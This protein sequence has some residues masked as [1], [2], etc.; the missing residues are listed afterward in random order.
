MCPL[1]GVWSGFEQP[2][3]GLCLCVS[4]RDVAILSSDAPTWHLLN[5]IENSE[6]GKVMAGSLY[7]LSPKRLKKVWACALQYERAEK[8]RCLHAGWKGSPEG[9]QNVVGMDQESQRM[10]TRG[11]RHSMGLDSHQEMHIGSLG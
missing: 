1:P 11:Y 2:R 4:S 10:A 3:L 7:T 9:G 6:R 8:L 5:L